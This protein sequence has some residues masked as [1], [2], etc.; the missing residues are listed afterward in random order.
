MCYF[1]QGSLV[2]IHVTKPSGPSFDP[3][4]SVVIAIM[5]VIKKVLCLIRA[6][7]HTHDIYCSGGSRILKGGPNVNVTNRIKRAQRVLGGVARGGTCHPRKIFDFRPSE[8]G[9]GAVLG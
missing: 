4:F 3:R 1:S 5:Q 9:F 7:D 8:I 6:E 2:V